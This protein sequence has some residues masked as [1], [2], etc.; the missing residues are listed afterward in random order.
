MRFENIDC[1]LFPGV[2]GGF[3]YQ[4]NMPPFCEFRVN[5]FAVRDDTFGSEYVPQAP[6]SHELTIIRNPH[7]AID[8]LL[9]T[10]PGA[11]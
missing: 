5:C 10:K 7:R 1:L 8:A 4:G 11:R 3:P 6:S 9:H 2:A